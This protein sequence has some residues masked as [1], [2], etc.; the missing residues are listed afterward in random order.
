LCGQPVRFGIAIL[1]AIC[2]PQVIGALADSLLEGKRPA[3]ACNRPRR[4][5][6]MAR[7]ASRK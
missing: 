2:S 3:N 6:R 1:A 5:T 4:Q 7:R